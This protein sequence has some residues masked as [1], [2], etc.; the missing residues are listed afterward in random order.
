MAELVG[1]IYI[2]YDIHSFPINENEV[3]RKMGIRLLPY[4]EF[5]QAERELL[6]KK[7]EDCI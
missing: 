7:Y 3:C 2:D 4:S 1:E 5:P 6:K